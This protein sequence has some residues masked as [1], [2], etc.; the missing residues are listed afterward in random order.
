MA[1]EHARSSRRRYLGFRE[2]YRKNRLDDGDEDKDKDKNKDSK[3]ASPADEALAKTEAAPDAAPS[4]G[5]RRAKRRQ[6]LR[7]YLRWLYPY[8]FAVGAF[9][10]LALGT[11]GLQMIEPLFMRFIIDKALLAPG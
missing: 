6:Y 3:P 5:A 4:K 1:G 8:R 2:D 9:A 10:L 7:E 11:A